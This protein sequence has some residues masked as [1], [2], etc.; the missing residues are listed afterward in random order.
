MPNAH[1]SVVARRDVA[2][3][4][5]RKR[6]GQAA[7]AGTGGTVMRATPPSRMK[8]ICNDQARYESSSSKRVEP[9]LVRSWGDLNAQDALRTALM[10]VCCDGRSHCDM[11]YSISGNPSEPK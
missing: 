9:V 6:N 4:L 1:P 2:E 7:A 11:R 10:T 3:T 8:R 5:C